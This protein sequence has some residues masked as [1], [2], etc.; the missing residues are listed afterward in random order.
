MLPLTTRDIGYLLAQ[1][2]NNFL[3][4]SAIH[5]SCFY[6]KLWFFINNK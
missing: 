3:S 6:S 4:K 2:L 5:W 1:I